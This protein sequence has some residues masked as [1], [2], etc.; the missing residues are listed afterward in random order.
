SANRALEAWIPPEHLPFEAQP[1]R[2]LLSSED[3]DLL[4]SV[5][6]EVIR[7]GEVRTL[8]GCIV[9]GAAAGASRTLWDV[10]VRPVTHFRGAV[11]HLLVLV[12]DVTAETAISRRLDPLVALT[13]VFRKKAEPLD[14]L[15]AAVRHAQDLVPNEGSL[16]ALSPPPG[17]DAVNVV[18]AS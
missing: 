6:E 15:R 12:A 4:T 13:A 16:V 17:E 7:T 2:R 8:A 18:A 11:T 9:E 10:E 1:W 14:L 5:A 3:A